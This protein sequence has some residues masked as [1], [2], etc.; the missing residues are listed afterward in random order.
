[1]SIISVG[2]RAGHTCLHGRVCHVSSGSRVLV[3]VAFGF[4]L[5]HV[6]DS[7]RNGKQRHLYTKDENASVASAATNYR[8]RRIEPFVR[9]LEGIFVAQKKKLGR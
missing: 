6:V 8:V 9:A 5:L 3:T 2:V 7:W 4:V 1:M